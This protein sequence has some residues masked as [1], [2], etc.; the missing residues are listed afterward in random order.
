[1]VIEINQ[2]GRFMRKYIK[3]VLNRKINPIHIHCTPGL[4]FIRLLAILFAVINTSYSCTRVLYSKPDEAVLVGNNMDWFEDM[5]TNLWVFP[6]G[7]KHTGMVSGQA[8]QWTSNYG[9]I[10]AT[11]YDLATTNGMNERGLAAHLLDLPGSNYGPRDE[12]KDGLSILLWAQFYL[13]N[14]STVNEAIQYSTEHPFQVVTYLDPKIKQNINLH[15]ALEDATG[16][17][18]IIEY[19]NGMPQIHHNRKYIIL[20]NEPAYEK[21]LEN[22]KS[23]LGFGGNQPLPGTTLAKD[24]F[25]RAAFYAQN[26][27]KSTSTREAILNLLSVLQNASQPYGSITPV[28]PNLSPTIWRAVSDLSHRIFY[29][30]SSMSFNIVWAQLDKFSLSPGSPVMKL[31]ISNGH[32]LVGDVTGQFK[33]GKF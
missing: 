30:N 33:Q 26:L 10:V 24:R 27:S 18:A 29:F 9:S 1:M 25:V 7:I 20:T 3:I 22:L 13:D 23:Y 8:M 12:Q 16:D 32:N 11:A 4:F 31:D 6:R 19:I 17:S 28:R 21:Q 14:F 15:L 2:V 5:K